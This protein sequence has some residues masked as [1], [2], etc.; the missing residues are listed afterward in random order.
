MLSKKHG[1]H[2]RTDVGRVKEDVEGIQDRKGPEQQHRYA[3][4]RGEN[5]ISS[6]RARSRSG[7]IPGPTAGIEQHRVRE[8]RSG[9]K[10]SRSSLLITGSEER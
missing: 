2:N 4:V 8:N 10:R 1:L 5:P 9:T 7:I 6:S 3:K